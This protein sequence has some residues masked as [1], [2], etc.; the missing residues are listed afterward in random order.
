MAEPKM[1][2]ADWLDDLTVRFI[3]NLPPGELSSVPRLCFQ[4]EEAQWFYEDFVRPAAAVEGDQLPSLNLRAF[5]LLLFQHCP[6]F[7]D[8]T[9]AQ[10]LE[11]YEEFLAYKVRVP[12]RGAILLDEA[13]NH[14]LL[15][16]GW[17]K[18]SSWAFPRG[19]IN[20]DE[21]DLDCAIREVYEETGYDIKAAG[22]VPDDEDNAK[23]IDV[24][25]KGQHVRLY[26]F[27]GVPL[28]TY[29][30]PRTRKEIS[31]IQWY[32]VQ[33]LPGFKKAKAQ[34]HDTDGEAVNTNKFY[35][36]A[37]FLGQLKKWIAQQRKQDKQQTNMVTEEEQNMEEE[38]A[39]ESDAAD[40]LNKLQG[41]RAEAPHDQATASAGMSH[42]ANAG[43]TLLA[44]LQGGPTQPTNIGI[45]QT[46]LDQI[47]QFPHQ[48]ET[49]Q[50]R[51]PKQQSVG[52]PQAPPQF[53]Y[54]PSHFQH[55]QQQQRPSL[56][57]PSVF[58]QGN[59]GGFPQGP[60]PHLHGHPNLQNQ[61][62]QSMQG[63]FTGN[64]TIPEPSMPF[65][66]GPQNH[67]Q[68]PVQPQ[69]PQ[70][71]LQQPH[72]TQRMQSEDFG[73]VGGGS[74]APRASEVPMP[75]LSTQAAN[76]LNAFKSGNSTNCSTSAYT[77]QQTSRTGSTQQSALLDL[78]NKPSTAQ[79]QPAQAAE[80][81][82]QTEAVPSAAAEESKA[83]P[84]RD[85]V[86]ELAATVIP[87]GEPTQTQSQKES[88]P[89]AP[90]P[91]QDEIHETFKQ[92]VAK[93]PLGSRRKTVKVQHSIHD[94]SG[95]RK[96]ESLPVEEKQKNNSGA[97][98]NDSS[99]DLQGD[100]ANGHTSQ[101]S[102]TPKKPSNARRDGK[103][104]GRANPPRSA[105]ATKASSEPPIQLAP[106]A[107]RPSE[108]NGGRKQLFD[109]AN[110]TQTSR[111]KPQEAQKPVTLA[112]RP[113]S[114]RRGQ[115]PKPKAS[116]P[117][118]APSTKPDQNGAL[119]P[120]FTILQRPG[121]AHGKATD[122]KD[123][124]A[125]SAQPQLLKRP[126][127]PA[128][129]KPSP[130]SVS[131]QASEK[132]V[133][134]SGDKKDDLLALLSGK[135]SPAPPQA[136]PNPPAAPQLEPTRSHN[137]P[138]DAG[139]ESQKNALL[140]LF[141]ASKA[142]SP[143][144]ATSPQP[145][146]SPPQT[147]QATHAFPP[148]KTSAPTNTRQS[149]LLD[150]FTKPGSPSTS[151]AATPISP[152]TLVGGGGGHGSGSGIH[153]PR[154]ETQQNPNLRESRFNSVVSAGSGGS[155]RASGAG[156]PVSPEDQKDFLMGYLNGVIGKEGG[157]GK[158]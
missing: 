23:F 20:K 27:R 18:G 105:D 148:R 66:N 62:R 91:P 31:K 56:P 2:L 141:G 8:F 49:P 69:M 21:K 86:Q 135:A 42:D 139:S 88:E 140:G 40:L 118:K 71:N 32:R 152:F 112:Q 150:L 132:P 25:M 113:A 95:S 4:V 51:H 36:I 154:F 103:S 147:Q 143:Q 89:V 5:A 11:A 117:T 119:T 155:R 59:H 130:L 30:E 96:V 24:T 44:M 70:E 6:L 64:G 3:L 129:H 145:T 65:T 67:P 97:T 128:E 124:S 82:V 9:P 76:L 133:Q 63:P 125:A 102:K 158:K 7:S 127:T 48:P 26:V 94:G 12:V 37:P 60:S 39:V 98:G 101:T 123:P 138:S 126:T 116:T 85:T 46:P 38:G 41:A 106:D 153:T 99:N 122:S 1:A 92:T 57:T 136:C 50:P 111:A 68:P 146:T 29:F 81:P 77:A 131:T 120:S 53:P 14:A 16:R 84:A 10:H 109:P 17:K 19:K 149:A 151:A 45:P 144:P 80:T 34:V 134:P 83:A 22:L 47:N 54:S 74:N 115:S 78:F 110:P 121:S 75:H 33:T 15:V 58:G 90:P 72:W 114:Q 142:P 52:Y 108:K 43:S 104:E 93:G 73:A 61:Y 137:R 156:T 100:E 13:M 107:P 79:T 28:N 87:P 157:A 55:L 35:M